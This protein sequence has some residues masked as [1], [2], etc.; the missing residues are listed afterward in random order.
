MSAVPVKRFQILLVEDNEADVFLL[1][2]ALVQ[3]G[4]T[5][6]LHVIESGAEAI[7]FLKGLD[8]DA[9]RPDLAVLDLNLPGPGGIEVLSALRG[10]EV[11]AEVPVCVV[12]S[13]SAPKDRAQVAQMGVGCFIKK[14]PDHE[15]MLA[16]GSALKD[17]LLGAEESPCGA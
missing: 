8:A 16:V 17:A 4:L 2:K 15:G 1:R 11:L 7:R 13:S 12:T 6:D 9:A 14:P 5:F 10:N 3:A